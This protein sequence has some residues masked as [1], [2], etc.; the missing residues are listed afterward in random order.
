MSNSKLNLKDLDLSDLSTVPNLVKSEEKK[1]ISEGYWIFHQLLSDI[2]H[3]ELATWISE[4][5]PATKPE[6]F[7]KSSFDT[8][9]K[10]QQAIDKTIQIYGH[11][12]YCFPRKKQLKTYSH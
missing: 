12:Q 10:R 5:F 6:G 11:I 1:E 2:T 7:K 9:Q 3:E 4:K 8:I